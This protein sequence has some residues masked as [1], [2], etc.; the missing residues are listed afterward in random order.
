M[1]QKVVYPY[2]CMDDW[3]KINE[4][5]L[6]E[7]EDFYSHLN[8]EDIPVSDYTREKRVCKDFEMKI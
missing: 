2:E 5:S 1:S 3:E 4:T 7:K 8:V 6:I